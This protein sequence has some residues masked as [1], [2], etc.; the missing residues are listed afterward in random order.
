MSGYH[1]DESELET[2]AVNTNPGSG[3]RLNDLPKKVNHKKWMGDI[4]D[5]GA[6]GSCAAFAATSTL[7]GVIAKKTKKPN[8]QHISEQHIVDC[9]RDTEKTRELFGERN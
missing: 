9:T 6:C 8:P 3:R 4:K 5:Q 1:A 2:S 7:E